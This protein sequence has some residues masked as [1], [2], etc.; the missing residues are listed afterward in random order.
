VSVTG[1]VSAFRAAP[2]ASPAWL[3]P[4]R[5]AAIERFATT[6]FPSPRTDEDW[7]FTSVAPIADVEWATPKGA[8]DSGGAS[9]SAAAGAPD[10]SSFTFGGG[11]GARIV[12]VNG[13]HLPALSRVGTLPH[14]VR[15]LPLASALDEPPVREHLTHLAV[16]TA[17]FTALNTA[18]FTD[19]VVIIVPADVEV[20]QPIHVLYA[21]DAAATGAAVHPRTLLLVGHHAAVTVIETYAGVGGGAYFTNAVTEVDVADG[22]RVA[23]YRIQ[24]ESEPAFHIG[25]TFVRQAKDSEYHGF[26]FATGGTLS[27]VTTE[28][29]LGGSGAIATLDG[30]Y[31]GDGV[32]HLDQQTRIEHVAPNCASRE[33]Y[34]GI[35][36][37]AAHGV[38]NGKVYV[39]PEAQQTDGKQTNNNLLL[40]DRAQIDTKPQLEIFADDVKCTHGATVGRLDELALF[41]LTSRGID[42]A[43]ARTLLTYAFAADVLQR[44]PH[45]GIRA[46]LETL[47]RA[48]FVAGSE[49]TTAVPGAP[50]RRQAVTV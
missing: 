47:A 48:R 3:T 30:L 7:H 17:A 6:G 50:S 10:L 49:P 5:A 21:S 31:M 28:D 19:G 16:P 4:I 18:S 2:P 26:S 34:K 44:I 11:D 37:D 15:I 22:A 12:F 24:R 9:G 35:L 41:Y 36:D 20:P 32:Q 39:H 29:V 38:F 1:F 23:H 43:L 25:T 8:R 13:R 27:R 46:G 42:A 40:S 33:I 14:G 45:D